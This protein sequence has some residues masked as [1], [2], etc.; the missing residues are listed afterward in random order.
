LAKAET[1]I[2]LL[3]H[4]DNVVR[5]ELVALRLGQGGRPGDA[6]PEHGTDERD[7]ARQAGGFE[8]YSSIDT[9]PIT[10][11]DSP[12]PSAG[13]RGDPSDLRQADTG[14]AGAPL[15][16][17]VGAQGEVVNDQFARIFIP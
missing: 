16:L 15:T 14:C 3:H 4:R 13:R 11:V 17:T 10:H 9:G 7:S 5:C 12:Q 6:A 1:L 2:A 8:E